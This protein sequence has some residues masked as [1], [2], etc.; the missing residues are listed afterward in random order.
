MHCISTFV[1][2]K[3]IEG[4]KVTAVHQK[5]ANAKRRISYAPNIAIKQENLFYQLCPTEHE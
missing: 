3:V 2:S 4:A 1:E 5:H